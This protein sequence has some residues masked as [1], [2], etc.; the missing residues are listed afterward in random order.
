VHALD[1]LRGAKLE[2]ENILTDLLVG[3]TA[4]HKVP[5][6]PFLIRIMI[7]GGEPPVLS[8]HVAV[9]VSSSSRGQVI[10]I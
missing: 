10:V 6:D 7:W 5:D 2:E 3:W 8:L 4:I 1:S 9:G